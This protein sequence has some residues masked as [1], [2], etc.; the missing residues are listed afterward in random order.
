MSNSKRRPERET[1]RSGS[2]GNQKRKRKKIRSYV[3]R[4]KLAQIK[5]PVGKAEYRRRLARARRA[6]FFR[7]FFLVIL[8]IVLVAAAGL[9]A[10][11]A[12]LYKQTGK[13]ILGYRNAAEKILDKSKAS[14]F[15]LAQPSYLYSSDGTQMAELSSDADAT[16]LD[17]DEIP[18]NVVNAFVAVEDQT[19]WENNGIDTKGIARVLFNYVRTGGS[20]AEGASTIT[21]QLAR[22]VYLTQ[23]KKISRKIEEIF[24]SKGLAKKYTKKQIM[25]YYC[26]NVC[27]ANGIYGIED[28]AQAYFGKSADELDL[29]QIAYLCAIPNRPEYYNPY[30]YP[31]HALTRRNKILTDM[32]QQGYINQTQYDKASSEKIK[33]KKKKT[34][35]KK[36]NY[37]TTYAVN[38]A[39]KYLMKQEGF[40]FQYE[41]DSTKEYNAYLAKYEE[42]YSQAEH[43][44]YT[45][46]YKITTTIDLDTQEKMQ[47]A[48]DDTL[49]FS[50]SKNSNGIYTLQGAMTVI[51][52]DTG[53]VAAIIGGRD[54][55]EIDSYSL[56]RAFQ[57]YRQP[58]STF[59]PLV[60]YTPALENGYSQYSSLKN[61]DVTAA[62]KATSGTISSMSGST[63][64]LRN[65]VTKSINGCA[66]WLFNEIKPA[67]GLAYVTDMKFTK[68]VPQDYTLSAALGGLTHGVTTV[69]MANAYQTLENHG[70]YTETDCIKTFLDS[71]GKDIYSAPSSKQ[72]YSKTAAD[73]MTD[74]LMNVITN[75]TAASM[76]WYS[77]SGTDAAGKTGTTNGSKDG[78]FCGYTPYY[79]ISVWVGYDQPK[80]LSNL[81]GGTYPATIWRKAMYALVKGKETKSFDIE[82]TTSH[83]SSGS[84]SSAGSRSQSSI[85]GDTGASADN[86]SEDTT[87]DKTDS[88]L[89]DNQKTDTEN[90]NTTGGSEQ[91]NN[92]Q[93]E[94]G[95]SEQGGN[96]GSSSEKKNGNSS[97]NTTG[98][99][100]SSSRT[101]GPSTTE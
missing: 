97:E 21:Q 25:E 70:E 18:A 94:N 83:Y 53:K 9:G 48:L 64:T 89:T 28:A 63:M 36:Y 30:K 49:S 78:W 5:N 98:G 52:N 24:L 77:Y 45:G 1:S 62:K 68:I 47:E 79:T 7:R 87:K 60:V 34:S 26:N 65:A 93:K 76:D 101:G 46:G 3:K 75:G 88:S 61:I 35:A 90:G 20:V 72:V 13:G 41:F 67:T 42:A 92:S 38:C 10:G 15:K 39:V 71:S 95:S 32:L 23:E 84:S 16:Y 50:T 44:L 100:E 33:I 66:Y 56:N 11:N 17:Y 55:D 54:Q 37:E 40:D 82:K 96:N 80:T 51:D 86:G 22:S 58:G 85:Q 57:S 19:F 99:K 12:Y 29:S 31:K 6:D 91:G 69:E 59:K 74:V 73:T 27:F 81:Y 2:G 43:E 4:V 14:D 8:V